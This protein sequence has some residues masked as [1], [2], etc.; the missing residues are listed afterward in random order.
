MRLLATCALRGLS[1]KVA[2][3]GLC[4]L[5]PNGTQHGRFA[6]TRQLRSRSGSGL[7]GAYARSRATC[8]WALPVWVRRATNA[9]AGLGPVAVARRLR[10]TGAR[11]GIM[12]ATTPCVAGMFCVGR[13]VERRTR[14]GQHVSAGPCDVPSGDASGTQGRRAVAFSRRSSRPGGAP[15]R[16]SRR[17]GVLQESSDVPEAAPVSGFLGR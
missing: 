1:R 10:V 5:Q 4:G 16:V 9:G 8:A 12:I 2:D 17:A 14:V 13:P 7:G 3:A 11:A 6:T 15:A